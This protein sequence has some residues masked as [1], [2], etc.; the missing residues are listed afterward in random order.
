MPS[1][2]KKTIPEFALIGDVDDWEAELTK[3]L[4]QLK[5]GSECVFHIDSAGG[6]VYG[7]MAILSLIRLR[8]LKVTSYVLGECSSAA[9]LI[10]AASHKRWVTPYSTLFFHRMRWESDKRVDSVEARHW[11]AHFEQLE[12]ELL[13]LEV[14]LLGNISKQL[15]RSWINEGRFITGRQVA[16]AGLARLHEL[17]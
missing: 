17:A 12:E 6:S 7:A 11:A 4:I 14:K 13:D 9:V 3:E 16:E 8:K 1:Q 5:P 15:V 10:F 2:R